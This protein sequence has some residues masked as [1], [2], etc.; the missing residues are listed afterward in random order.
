MKS[1]APTTSKPIITNPEIRKNIL[2]HKCT[3]LEKLK[4]ATHDLILQYDFFI[5]NTIVL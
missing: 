5:S 3:Q 1:E 2:S 4:R